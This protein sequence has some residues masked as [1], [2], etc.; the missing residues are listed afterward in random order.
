MTHK[1]PI[2]L[3]DYRT[4]DLAAVVEL[5]QASVHGLTAGRRAAAGERP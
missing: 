2:T 4:E 1:P 3:R 5:F